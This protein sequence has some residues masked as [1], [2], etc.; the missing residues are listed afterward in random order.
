MHDFGADW[1]RTMMSDSKPKRPG[2]EP[3][4]ISERSESRPIDPAPSDPVP[5]ILPEP[6]AVP[7]AVAAP[8]ADNGMSEPRFEPESPAPAVAA[9]DDAWTALTEVQAALARGFAE[10]AAEMTGMTRS[11]VAVA[12]DAAVAMLGARTFAEAVEIN[13]TLARRGADAM[14]EG[15]AKLSE[16][17][18]TAMSEATR[19]ILSRLGGIGIGAR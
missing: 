19:P 15:S 12:A 1:T 18:V 9:S 2:R 5:T 7:A 14:I 13:A 4:R 3:G 6:P 10:I 16:I 11:G 17:G 8:P